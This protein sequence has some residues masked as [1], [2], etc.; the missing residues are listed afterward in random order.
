MEVSAVVAGATGEPVPLDHALKTLTLADTGH[1]DPVARREDVN[2]DGIA[3][4]RLVLAAHL[5]EIPLGRHAGLLE[6][7]L[8]RLAEPLGLDVVERD[9]RG[10][11]PVGLDRLL[12]GHRAGPSL[13]DRAP[14]DRAVLVEVLGHTQL[15][16]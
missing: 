7:P 10:G 2:R 9:L 16:S 13:D 3:D 5:A 6:V 15:L 12:L 11:V 14:D 4:G 1:L 8:Q